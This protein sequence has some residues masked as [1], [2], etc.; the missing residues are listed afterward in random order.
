MAY[1]VSMTTD[2]RPGSAPGAHPQAELSGTPVVAGV[3]AGP[4]VHVITDVSPE[5]VA[6]FGDG[7]FGGEEEALAAYD[8][9]VAFVAET[10][11]EKA[12]IAHGAAAEVLTASAGLV[13][14]KGLRSAVAKALGSGGGPVAAVQA[15]VDQFVTLFTSM[16]G[17]MAERATDLRDIERRLVARLVGE[18]AIDL[19]QEPDERDVRGA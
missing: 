2:A 7:G 16:G 15:A 3:A 9:A 10:F 8:D 17:L 5:A 1:G 14:D 18:P 6:R 11:T 13:R 12:G 19:P 4:A